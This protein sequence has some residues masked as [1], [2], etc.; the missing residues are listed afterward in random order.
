MDDTGFS[1]MMLAGVVVTGLVLTAAGLV[2][3]NILKIAVTRRMGRYGILRAIG[4]QKRQLY[5]IVAAEVLLL[6]ALGIP[7]GMLLGM[8]SAKGILEAALSQLSP[9]LFLV[10]DAVRLQELIAASDSGKWGFP[11]LSA[12]I[13]PCVCI[14]AAAARRHG[15]RRRCLR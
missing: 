7:F 14:S 2:I 15:T 10:Q 9:E 3:Y 8:L 11:A 1:Y 6:C 12:L 5:G 4:A 13:T